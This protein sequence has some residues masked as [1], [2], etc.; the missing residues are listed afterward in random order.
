MNEWRVSRGE[1]GVYAFADAGALVWIGF[2]RVRLSG[3]CL[4]QDGTLERAICGCGVGD[5]RVSFGG[6]WFWNDRGV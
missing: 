5:D 2:A 6:L 4:R 1:V 3:V